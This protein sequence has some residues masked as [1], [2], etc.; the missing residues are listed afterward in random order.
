MNYSS[1]GKYCTFLKFTL[2]TFLQVKI[3]KVT[4]KVLNNDD[5]RYITLQITIR[6]DLLEFR[7]DLIIFFF[8]SRFLT[9]NSKFRFFSQ[10]NF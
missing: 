4:Y 10:F 9:F 6:L 3:C 1:K 2:V 5:T 8:F 7:F